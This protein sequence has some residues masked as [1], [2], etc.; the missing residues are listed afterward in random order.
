MP[1]NAITLLFFPLF[2]VV[3]DERKLRSM[4]WFFT[5][6]GYVPV[7]LLLLVLYIPAN[8][9]MLPFSYV[10]ALIKKVYL[11]R[12]NSVLDLILF[13]IFGLLI[14][15]VSVIKDSFE[16]TLHLFNF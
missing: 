12:R 4:N 9:I 13:L 1:F 7:A 16:F 6:I 8:L 11:I 15:L 10:A 2:I 14:L 5:V 3:K